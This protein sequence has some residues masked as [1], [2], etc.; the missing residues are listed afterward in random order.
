MPYFFLGAASGLMKISA[1][2]IKDDI[3]S[4]C[5]LIN[6]AGIRPSLAKLICI[7][8]SVLFHAIKALIVSLFNVFFE[9]FRT[10]HVHT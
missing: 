2:S 5:V 3:Y 6:C 10:S 9:T 4:R 1:R 7:Q 8:I